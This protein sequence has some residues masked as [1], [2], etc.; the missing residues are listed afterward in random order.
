[1]LSY[2]QMRQTSRIVICLHMLVLLVMTE[3]ITNG[4]SA[5]DK[6]SLFRPPHWL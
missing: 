4:V 1:M 5:L 3:Y 6:S 2:S